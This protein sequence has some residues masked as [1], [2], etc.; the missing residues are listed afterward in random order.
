MFASHSHSEHGYN[1]QSLVERSLS[2]SPQCACRA[3]RHVWPAA[4]AAA[5]GW[6]DPRLLRSILSLLLLVAGSFTRTSFTAGIEDLLYTV[7]TAPG[8]VAGRELLNQVDW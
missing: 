6:P 5:G 8:E 4:V 2:G 7:V 3:G 1:R